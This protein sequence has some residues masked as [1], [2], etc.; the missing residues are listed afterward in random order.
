MTYENAFYDS[1]PPGEADI[2][3]FCG[4]EI[5]ISGRNMEE[6]IRHLEDT[7]NFGECNKNKMFYRADHFSQHK[8]LARCNGQEMDQIGGPL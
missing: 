6:R 1:T 8:I 4:Y 7:H 2:C 3:G 5:L